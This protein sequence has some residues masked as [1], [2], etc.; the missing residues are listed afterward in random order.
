MR[1]KK[2]AL[3]L[4]LTLF[5]QCFVVTGL[6]GALPP[7]EITKVSVSVGGSSRDGIVADGGLTGNIDLTDV[8]GSATLESITLTATGVEKLVIQGA[9]S[10]QSHIT[11]TREFEFAGDTLT[12]SANDFLPGAQLSLLQGV[13]GDSVTVYGQIVSGGNYEDAAVVLQLASSAAATDWGTYSKSGTTITATI[14]RT[15]LN[16]PILGALSLDQIKRL[17]AEAV[18]EQPTGIAKSESGTYHALSN[19]LS[20]LKSTFQALF[21]ELNWNTATFQNLIDNSPVWLQ[22]AG[23]NKHKL[24][25]RVESVPGPVDPGGP[26][27]GTVTPPL[28]TKPVENEEGQQVHEV[29]ATAGMVADIVTAKS[30]GETSFA[31]DVTAALPEDEEVDVVT[32]RIPE[33]IVSRLS[34]LEVVLNTPFGD[35]TLPEALVEALAAAG[36]EFTITLQPGDAEAVEAEIAETDVVLTEP[37]EVNTSITGNTLVTLSCNLPLPAAGAERDAF[38]SSLYVLAI[39]DADDVEQIGDIVF[40]IDEE[41]GTLLAITFQ[42]DRFSTFA[43]IATG[44]E[45]EVPQDEL[46]TV[47]D[48]RTYT[49]NEESKTFDN[50]TSYRVNDGTTVMAVRLLQELGAKIGYQ[51]VNNVGVVTVT[52]DGTVATLQEKSNVM[53]VVDAEGTRQVTLRTVFTNLNGRTY[54]PT[55]DVAENLGFFVHWAAQTDSITITAR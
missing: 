43:L 14:K 36:E 12:I 23:A 13:F 24:V 26:G 27:G 19:D 52:F 10:A 2:L 21:P 39:H 28:V 51:R 5:I 40:D 8:P 6:A 42:V 29:A 3:I 53:T 49:I 22:F 48:S 4:A 9:R 54:L 55:R 7:L 11:Y 50:V 1:H 35:I 44:Q 32:V 47:I 45:V 16:T 41:T 30:K 17:A 38:L 46:V 20:V 31:I 25:F 37:V 15:L 34:G 33:D 18:G